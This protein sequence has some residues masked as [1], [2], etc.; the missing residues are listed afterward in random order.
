MLDVWV[1][2]R[3][4]GRACCKGLLFRRRRRLRLQGLD[5]VGAGRWDLRLWWGLLLLV[6]NADW[7]V[8][9]IGSFWWRWRE[10]FRRIWVQECLFKLN[11]QL[12]VPG[13]LL[14]LCDKGLA[15]CVHVVLSSIRV[16]PHFLNLGESLLDLS[17]AHLLLEHLLVLGYHYSLHRLRSSVLRFLFIDKLLIHLLGLLDSFLNRYF[18]CFIKRL[19]VVLRI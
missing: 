17:L 1:D 7:Y 3:L 10:S 14:L 9:G 15:T 8:R 12:L 19:L 5:G 18:L 2:L 4:L 13:L 6:L 11:L 16:L